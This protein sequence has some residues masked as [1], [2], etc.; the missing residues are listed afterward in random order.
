MAFDD[1]GDGNGQYSIYNYARDPYTGHYDY[2]LVGDYQGGKLTMRARPIW[3]GGQ[4]SRLPVSQ[5]S[6][7]CG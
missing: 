7:E 1:N 3:P 5:C 4:S 2:R 6:E